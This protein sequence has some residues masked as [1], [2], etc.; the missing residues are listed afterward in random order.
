[1][2][3]KLTKS[4]EDSFNSDK[5]VAESDLMGQLNTWKQHHNDFQH[6]WKEKMCRIDSK[7]IWGCWL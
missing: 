2:N 6:Q 4:C 1:L 7:V 5:T 3:N